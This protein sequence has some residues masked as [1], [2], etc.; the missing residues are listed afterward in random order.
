MKAK[1]LT[2]RVV[3]TGISSLTPPPY[4]SRYPGPGTEGSRFCP[5]SPFDSLADWPVETVAAAVVDA[6]GTHRHGPTDQAFP[7][8]SVTKLLTA[9]AALV[10]HEEGT[11]PLDEP[12]VGDDATAADLLAHSAGIAPDV[13]EPMT[14]APPTSHLLDGRLRPPRRPHHRPRRHRLPRLSARGRRRSHSGCTSS[15]STDRRVPVAEH[16]STTCSGSP[17]PGRRRCSSIAS[18]LTRATQPH[19]GHLSGVLPGFGR[20]DPNPWGLG[21]EIR[22]EKSPHWTAPENSP[23][24][25]GHFGQSG[26]MLWI[27]PVARRDGDRPV[28]P[29]LRRLGDHRLAAI[30]R[31]AAPRP[32]ERCPTLQVRRDAVPMETA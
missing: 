30:L 4:R 32:A 28:R 16:R 17:K 3:V 5:M 15:D 21:P 18:T 29:R 26:T 9:M 2:T 11:L 25:F 7:L 12:I 19:R 23:A 1:A 13:P 27:D 10:A 14:P 6:G 22:G 24:T 20:H 31:C 8:A